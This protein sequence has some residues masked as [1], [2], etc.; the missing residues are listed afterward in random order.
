MT[1]KLY[2]ASTPVLTAEDSAT[3]LV[4]VLE[5][6]MQ[7]IEE[8]DRLSAT[9]QPETSDQLQSERNSEALLKTA[10]ALIVQAKSVRISETESTLTALRT[11]IRKA[12]SSVLTQVLQHDEVRPLHG[13]WLGIKNTLCDPDFP[14]DGELG[15]LPATKKDLV[16][17][18][19][20]AGGRPEK[21]HLF[22][23]LVRKNAYV[24]NGNPYLA[25]AVDIPIGPGADG[26]TILQNLGRIGERGLLP[27]IIQSAP[28]FCGVETWSSLPV[29]PDI[30]KKWYMS[31]EMSEYREYRK[32]SA[33]RFTAIALPEVCLRKPYG[34]KGKESMAYAEFEEL[35][36]DATRLTMGSASH[37]VFGRI[38]AAAG[39]SGWTAEIV[40][41]SGGKVSGLAQV[42]FRN[43]FGK[44]TGQNITTAIVIDDLLEWVL[45]N[46]FGFIPISYAQDS[47]YGVIYA[48]GNVKEAIVGLDP[49]KNATSELAAQLPYTLVA[50]L[51]GQRLHA[52]LR[53]QIGSSLSRSQLQA[54]L[55]NWADQYVLT[56]PD[57][58]GEEARRLRPF[59]EIRVLEKPVSGSADRYAY[60]LE[61][62]PHYLL[63]AIK[64]T[65]F[66]C[67][68]ADPID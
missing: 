67:A 68:D 48:A 43:E 31:A 60:E 13:H 56:D 55:Q 20:K 54:E 35:F 15:I 46:D 9:R 65:I 3:A 17:D 29:D 5:R 61:I 32:S 25:A 8:E 19:R 57:S 63:R 47:A 2:P 7:Q 4:A 40:G 62:I 49:R 27:F 41:R 6:T 14:D 58:S 22:F 28:E 38:M 51:L 45:C 53:N 23:E 64:V 10:S 18:F 50:C 11:V 26:M 33:S 16:Q 24:A 36:A 59:K 30:L 37:A 44:K 42:E 12:V 66:V 1:T 34:K 39:R 21:T 52:R